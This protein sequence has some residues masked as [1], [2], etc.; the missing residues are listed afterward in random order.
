[1]VSALSVLRAMKKWCSDFHR[2]IENSNDNIRSDISEA[3]DCLGIKWP[4]DIIDHRNRKIAGIIAKT[5]FEGSVPGPIVIGIGINISNSIPDCLK[6]TAYSLSH[7]F[8][9]PV[10]NSQIMSLANFILPELKNDY[11]QLCSKSFTVFKNEMS[12]QCLTIGRQISIIGPNGSKTHGYAVDIDDQGRLE[13]QNP[14]KSHT[15]LD[16]GEISIRNY[17]SSI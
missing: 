6:A 12:S 2:P 13:V 7:L 10:P 5:W 8:E 16:S 17:D 14:D 1:M 3:I 15:F 9:T 4:N 11:N